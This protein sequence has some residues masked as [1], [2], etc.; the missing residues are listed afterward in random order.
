MKRVSQKNQK[1]PL[2]R[3]TAL[4][5]GGTRGIGQAIVKQLV[6]DGF[7]VIINYPRASENTQKVKL[8]F[9][10]VSSQVCFLEADVSNEKAV[11]RMFK[12]IK[13]DFKII[14]VVINNAGIINNIRDETIENISLPALHCLV[15]VNLYGGVHI[16]REA[17]P[18]MKKSRRGR[19]VFINS[20]L[21][22]VGSSRRFGYIASKTANVGVVR[23]LVHELAPWNIC[24]NAV[25]PGYIRT[26]MSN[27]KGKVL[28]AKLQK[29]PLRRL[30]NPKEVADL[31][32]FL[33]STESNYI[34][35]QHI[36]INGGLYLS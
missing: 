17:L 3:P 25:V 4:V 5:T 7:F 24:V 12:I 1:S 18:L 23:A 35:G 34:T 21:S 14:D 9:K 29:I 6:Q 13:K 22:F 8:Q 20:A 36:H 32:S 27:F 15:D 30:G 16:L 2:P 10:K 11:K 26:R 19:V 33:C 28:K 31:V